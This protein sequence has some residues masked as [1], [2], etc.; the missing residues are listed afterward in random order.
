MWI[1]WWKRRNDST[2]SP[3]RKS[4]P[5][6]RTVY[7]MFR[8]QCMMV[9]DV[10]RRTENII[11]IRGRGGR[12]CRCRPH[13]TFSF[14]TNDWWYRTAEYWFFRRYVNPNTFSVIRFI[15]W[16]FSAHSQCFHD[17]RDVRCALSYSSL[18][19]LS[20]WKRNHFFFRSAKIWNN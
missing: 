20:A 6:N 14:V 17:E 1:K 7:S 19:Q 2:A 15:L 11:G 18:N 13:R 16:N 4:P 8:R 3:I 10:Q 12:G 5:N 9:Y